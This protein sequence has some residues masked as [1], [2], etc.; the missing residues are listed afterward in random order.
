MIAI[1]KF[2]VEP[3]KSGKKLVYRIRNANSVDIKITINHIVLDFDKWDNLNQSFKYKRTEK[4]YK[5]SLEVNNSVILFSQFIQEEIY[6]PE[7]KNNKLTSKWLREKYYDFFGFENPNQ[8]K[9]K[10]DDE[11]YFIDYYNHLS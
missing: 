8:N 2:K 4:D 3:T 5:K 9:D 1:G 7:I 11:P 10:I 6:S